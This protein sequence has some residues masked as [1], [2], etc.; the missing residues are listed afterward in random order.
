MRWASKTIAGFVVLALI[1]MSGCVKEDGVPP[2]YN[3]SSGVKEIC[4][5]QAQFTCGGECM[6]GFG[7]MCYF[8]S[9]KYNGS[10]LSPGLHSLPNE[11]KA[12]CMGLH[13]YA[14]CGSCF[15]RFEL[16]K[17][18]VLTNV[19]CEEFYQAIEDANRTCGGCVKTVAAG[20]C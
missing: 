15:N 13:S 8:D 18:S 5:T 2:A 6:D 19:S 11:T 1:L 12:A 20:C 14:H 10:G 4:L 9:V 3:F 7:E 16:R 17:N